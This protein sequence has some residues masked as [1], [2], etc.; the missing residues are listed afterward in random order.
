MWGKLDPKGKY[1]T[2]IETMARKAHAILLYAHEGVVLSPMAT[3]EQNPIPYFS[4]AEFVVH[5]LHR[6]TKPLSE[7]L[8][9]KRIQEN[10]VAFPFKNIHEMLVNMYALGIVTRAEKRGYVIR[11]GGYI[12]TEDMKKLI[13]EH[14]PQ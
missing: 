5:L 3:D 10:N 14:K 9:L 6:S 1:F 13:E 12:L 7:N 2:G 4:S 11:Q 8:I